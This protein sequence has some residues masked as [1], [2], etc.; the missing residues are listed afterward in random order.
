MNILWIEDFGGGLDSGTQ[1]LNLLFQDLLSFNHWD[2]DEWSLLSSP[3][4]LQRYCQKNSALHC[5][6]LCRHYFDYEAFKTNND[7]IRKID[8]VIIDIRL[9]NQVDFDAP[10]PINS[11]AKNKFHIEA[12][13]YIFNDLVHFGFPAE[14]MC[15]MTG[16]TNS[17]AEFSEKCAE[18]YIPKVVGFEKSDT[19][20]EKLRQWIK[21]QAVDYSI[22]RRGII[23]GCEFLNQHID[24]NDENVQFRDFIKLENNQPAIEVP[25][26][27]IKN[28]LDALSQSLAIRQP[29]DPSSLNIRYRL[30]LRTLSHEW[31]ESIEANSL[32]QRHGNDFSNIRDIYT[33]AWIMKMTRNW[34]VHAKLLEPLNEQ[35]IAFLILVN[36]RAMFRL[37]KAIQPYEQ[38][39]LC[40]ITLSPEHGFKFDE[41]KDKIEYAEC[42]VDEHLTFLKIPTEKHFG[43]KINAIYRQVTGNPDAEEYDFKKF[44]FQYFWINQKQKD[45]SGNLTACSDDFLP[46]LARHI[47]HYSFLDA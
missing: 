38:I 16:E 33:F 15:F 24:Q 22:L 35:F 31:E 14:K 45:S 1:T 7:L 25:V 2:E 30:F 21:E 18:I 29:I 37:P 40:L 32:K 46:T 27:E 28:Y 26:M 19:G 6:Y 47:Y 20:Y 41:I 36:M 5:I 12:G 11:Q 8:A 42:L 34:V 17:L 3:A 9:D 13:F 43:E 10:I 39:L 23:E 4:D 44:L